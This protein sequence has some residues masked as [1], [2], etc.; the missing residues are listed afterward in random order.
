MYRVVTSFVVDNLPRGEV[1]FKEKIIIMVNI[2]VVRQTQEN[3]RNK[4]RRFMLLFL[5]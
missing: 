4:T 1:G 3:I 5:T 2:I